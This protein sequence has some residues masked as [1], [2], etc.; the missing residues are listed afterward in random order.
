MELPSCTEFSLGPYTL[1]LDIP[2]G[3]KVWRLEHDALPVNLLFDPAELLVIPVEGR[4]DFAVAGWDEM[5]PTVAESGNIPPFGL[6]RLAHCE[7]ARQS[8]CVKSTWQ[9]PELTIQR[10]L[11]FQEDGISA[12]YHFSNLSDAP[13]P[14]LWASH[15]LFPVKDLQCALLPKGRPLPGPGCVVADLERVIRTGEQETIIDTFAHTGESWKFFVPAGE[16]A[17]LDYA[18]HRVR[19]HSEAG[20]YGIFLN[21]GRFGTPCIG[22]E[23]TTSP[24]DYAHESAVIDPMD[25]VRAHW[26]LVVEAK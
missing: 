10:S 14:F 22:I 2:N 24:T 21:R 17:V 15:M 5:C 6:A 25:T 23:P 3:G 20:W 12:T 4:A 11:A 16:P 18:T 26:H 19:I 8:E 13:A 9:L 7:T 1:W